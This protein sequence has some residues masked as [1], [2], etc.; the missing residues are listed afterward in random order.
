MAEILDPSGVTE[1]HP[2]R[3]IERWRGSRITRRG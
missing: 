2:T 3:V 1:R